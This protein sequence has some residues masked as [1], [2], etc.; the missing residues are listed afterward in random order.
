MWSLRIIRF[1]NSKQISKS[2]GASLVFLSLNDMLL[3][4]LGLCL[5]CYVGLSI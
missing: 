1:S 4:H 2:K 3:L 5:K